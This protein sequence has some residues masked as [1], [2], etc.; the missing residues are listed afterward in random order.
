VPIFDSGDF[1][2]A[3]SIAT[4]CVRYGTYF[5]SIRRGETRPHVFSWFNW[6]LVVAI[7]AAAQYKL[8]GG[9]SAL[10]LVFVSATCFMFALWS[11]FVGEKQITRSDW[12]A[13]IA[14]LGTL[15]VWHATGNVVLALSLLILFDVFSYWPTIRRS[16]VDPWGE[17]P[18]SYF[19]AGL[20]YFWLLFA[21]TTPHVDSLLYPFWLMAT[22]W[23]F[24]L[25]LVTRRRNLENG[26]I[27]PG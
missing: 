16:W 23:A 11:L 4:G 22:D 13:F 27:L 15:A 8:D 9:P 2:V 14:A 7:G 19:W 5:L 1:F 21:V 18:N 25:F 10:G 12:A 20:R 6:G 3:L 24:A 26:R 17:P